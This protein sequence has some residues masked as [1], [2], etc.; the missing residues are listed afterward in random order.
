MTAWQ[1]LDETRSFFTPA[2]EKQV[3]NQH[4]IGCHPHACIPPVAVLKGGAAF[5][6]I[7]AGASE[8]QAN[9]RWFFFSP[10]LTWCIRLFCRGLSEKHGEKG[11]E[12]VVERWTWSS[13]WS[14]GVSRTG[15]DLFLDRNWT[16]KQK[17]SRIDRE[18]RLSN[19]AEGET[20]H[21]LLKRAVENLEKVHFQYVK[22]SLGLASHL[23]A[24]G[25]LKKL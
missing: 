18:K 19:W 20:K 25:V 5:W 16:K 6:R 17:S 9:V 10:H 14:H 24:A 7:L 12:D 15:T 1:T 13:L 21:T 4:L 23:Q 11:V 8:P 22:C 3:P 2:L